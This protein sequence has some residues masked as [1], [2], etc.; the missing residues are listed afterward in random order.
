[1]LLF[2]TQ[3]NDMTYDTSQYLSFSPL[4]RTVSLSE[5]S[6]ELGSTVADIVETSAAEDQDSVDI[7]LATALKVGFPLNICL[8]LNRKNRNTCTRPPDCFQNL[9]RRF[10]C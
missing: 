3:D 9:P 1:M 6:G 10:L 7:L 8:Y 4:L 5:A 2:V